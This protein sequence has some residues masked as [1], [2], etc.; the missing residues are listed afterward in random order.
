MPKFNPSTVYK[1]P[2]DI[3]EIALRLMNDGTDPATALG[4]ARMLSSNPQDP[5]ATAFV[6]DLMRRSEKADARN[7]RVF[8]ESY[9]GVVDKDF[10]FDAAQNMVTRLTKKPAGRNYIRQY[11]PD[12]YAGAAIGLAGAD[13]RI[14]TEAALSASQGNADVFRQNL[15]DLGFDEYSAEQ[16]VRRYT[17]TIIR[18]EPDA[19]GML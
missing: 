19:M 7:L 17:P 15:L 18:Q 9:N 10:F 6:S 4:T 2:K 16:L 13:R 5:Q 3:G 12:E 1:L 11:L 8:D 14:Y